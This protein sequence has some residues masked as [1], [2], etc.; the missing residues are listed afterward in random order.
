[1]KT[2]EGVFN[3]GSEWQVIKELSK[4]FPDVAVSVLSGALIIK[5]IHLGDLSGF[6]VT[7]EDD[8]SVFVSDFEGNQESDGFDAVMSWVMKCNYLDQRSHPWRGS[9]IRGLCHRF[10]RVPLSR[11]IG[12]ECHRI[13]WQGRGRGRRWVIM[14]GFLWPES[15]EIS[16]LSQSCLMSASGRGLHWKRYSICLSRPPMSMFFIKIWGKI[17][18]A[19]NLNS[20]NIDFYIIVPIKS[21]NLSFWSIYFF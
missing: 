1:M 9:W 13:R 3:N 18:K 19:S 5:S 7:S 10:Q 2:E 4:G 6:V 16:T 14:K 17:I 15:D 12:H 21:F 20:L 8:N 11:G